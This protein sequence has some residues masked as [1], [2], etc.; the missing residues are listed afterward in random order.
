MNHPVII[1]S[2]GPGD[3]SLMNEKTLSALKSAGKLLLRTG[4]H[5]VSGWLEKQSVPFE[6]MDSL[7]ET[8]EDFDSLVSSVAET[9]WQAAEK[10]PVVYAV[11]DV[12]TDRSVDA[13][14]RRRPGDGKVTVVPGFSYADFYLS[15]CRGLFP[16]ADLRIC[17]ANDF[18]G[19]DYDPS[20]PVLIT[21]LNDEITAGEIK[22][23]LSAFLDDEWT[24]W[25]LDGDA[26]PQPI[27]LYELDRQAS[28]SH[29]SAVASA[30]CPYLMRNAKTLE[31]LVQVMDLLRSPEGCPWDREQTHRSLRPYVV[32][33]A[34]E[35]VDSIDAEDS[36]HLAEELGDLLFQVVFH[37]SIGKSFDEF[38]ISDVISG[39]TNKMIRRHPHVFQENHPGRDSFSP[40]IWEQLKQAETGSRTIGQSLEDVSSSLP[41]LRYAEKVIR[42][43]DQLPQL[44]RSADE[45]KA[46]ILECARGLQGQDREET[47]QKIASLLLLCAELSQRLGIDSEVLLHQSVRK[48]VGFF[49]RYEGNHDQDALKRLT[50]N[51]FGVY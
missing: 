24:V 19:S 33:E 17:S 25:F 1:V 46:L 48:M 23:R 13:V 42:K 47:E 2:V 20:L 16:T 34:W 41:S 18:P 3:P 5:P 29:L 28:Y 8:A 7:Y 45:V 9:V 32:E 26:A 6:T 10:S 40:V 38:T 22:N 37:S 50:F 44:K 14:F 15:S 11:P 27:P 43:L 51:D 21:E 4:R 31:D 30:G 35:V 12:Q 39:I 36:V 49:L